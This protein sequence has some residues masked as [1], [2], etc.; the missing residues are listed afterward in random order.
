M[1][2]KYIQASAYVYH[3][4]YL[5]SDKGAGK[6]HNII[7]KKMQEQEKHLKNKNLF[8]YYNLFIIIMLLFFN[9]INTSSTCFSIWWIYIASRCLV[10][11][12]DTRN[13]YFFN[14]KKKNWN[15]V[16][17]YMRRA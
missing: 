5:A 4:I 14:R 16:L 1:L 2:K 9:L 11:T 15:I 12:S 8:Q 17:Y 3:Y 10:A 6:P 7:M 13:I